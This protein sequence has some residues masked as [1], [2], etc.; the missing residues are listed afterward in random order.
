MSEWKEYRV[1]AL[2][3]SGALTIGDGYRA[4]NIELS[5][6]GIPFAR[7]A[8]ID[9]GFDFSSADFFPENDLGKVGEKI[10]RPGDIVFTSK[11][12]VGRFAFVTEM[13]P[14][15]VYSP[16]LSY[17]RSHDHD[18]IDPRFLFYWMQGRGFYEQV[19]AVK[20]QTDMADYVSLADQR[21]MILTLPE[22]PEQRAIASVL[23][24]LDDKIDLLHRQNK[25]LEALAET[26][27]RQWFVEEAEDGWEEKGLDEIADYLNG[28]ACQKYPAENAV[29]RLPVIKIKELRRGFTEASDWATSRVPSKYIIETGDVIFSWSGS[30]EVV[31]WAHGTGVLNQHLFKVTSQLYPK[32]FYYLATK[33]LLPEF[34]GIAEDKA[35]TMGHIQRHHLSDSKILVPPIEDFPKLDQT[36]KPILDRMIVNL[37]SLRALSQMRD[38]LLPKL[39]RGEMRIAN[40]EVRIAND[41]VRIANDDEE[42]KRV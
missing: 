7:V 22:I 13:T 11:G 4:K 27:F 32:W 41:E 8:N 9:G 36:M 28:L 21:Q 10:S 33:S 16:Q 2:I 30:L 15:F 23:S 34:Q 38:M 18:M 31:I 37:K 5:T 3:E 6:T 17:W 40:D 14:R 39:M 12:T 25:T 19:E 24:S 42:A 26:L 20:G 35:T 29:D 1:S